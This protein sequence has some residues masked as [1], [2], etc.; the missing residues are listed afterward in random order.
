MPRWETSILVDKAEIL[1]E[2]RFAVKEWVPPKKIILKYRSFQ[3]FNDLF[4]LTDSPQVQLW[5]AW[6]ILHACTI[7]GK[8]ILFI[9]LTIISV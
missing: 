4:H 8:C 5:A 1:K 9:T 3:S 2:L 7:N 6:A